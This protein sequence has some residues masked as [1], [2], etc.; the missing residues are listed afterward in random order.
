MKYTQVLE[1]FRILTTQ[2]LLFK[3]YEAASQQWGPGK[4]SE[5]NSVLARDGSLC[6]DDSGGH[7]RGSA[8]SC[9]HDVDQT[10]KRP[11]DSCLLLC[12][13]TCLP[14]RA[15]SHKCTLM[16]M[17]RKTTHTGIHMDPMQKDI[18]RTN[19]LLMFGNMFNYLMIK[20]VI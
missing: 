11:G 18:L 5:V 20:I 1:H 19:I 2:F 16:H 6:A 3:P 9:C 10:G 12:R 14:A 17:Q 8:S 13:S 7:T 15:Q 4:G